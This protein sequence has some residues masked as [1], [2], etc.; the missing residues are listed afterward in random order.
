MDRKQG[1]MTLGICKTQWCYELLLKEFFYW[2]KELERAGIF[3]CNK[4]W[5]WLAFL[6]AFCPLLAGTHFLEK[7]S[8][9]EVS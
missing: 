7:M 5:Y 4:N 6:G 9:F 3:G 2:I 8:I 1:N